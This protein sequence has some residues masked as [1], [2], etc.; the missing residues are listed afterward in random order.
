MLVFEVL[1]AGHFLLEEGP[2][3]LH[4]MFDEMLCMRKHGM[5][6]PCC[7]PPLKFV[8]QKLGTQTSYDELLHGKRKT[9]NLVVVLFIFQEA[10]HSKTFFFSSGFLVLTMDVH[11]VFFH[12][13]EGRPV[14]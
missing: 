13:F 8:F 5:I 14:H 12:L 11:C 9:S 7:M 1:N 3:E 6:W 10:I 4:G 2:Y